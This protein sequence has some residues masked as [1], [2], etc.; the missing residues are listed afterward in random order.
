MWNR[1]LKILISDCKRYHQGDDYARMLEITRRVCPNL[2]SLSLWVCLPLNAY[3]FEYFVGKNNI[4]HQ[5]FL[6]NIECLSPF[7]IASASNGSKHF[8]LRSFQAWVG[9][10]KRFANPVSWWLEWAHAQSI[11]GYRLIYSSAWLCFRCH[12]IRDYAPPTLTQLNRV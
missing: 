9:I 6:I 5:F 1:Q 12:V 2:R 7:R 11:A 3:R 10:E 8:V 4:F